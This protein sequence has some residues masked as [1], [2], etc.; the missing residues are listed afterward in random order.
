M[1]S[2]ATEQNAYPAAPGGRRDVTASQ[3]SAIPFDQSSGMSEHT[4]DGVDRRSVMQVFGISGLLGLTGYTAPNGQQMQPPQLQQCQDGED[5]QTADEQNHQMLEQIPAIDIPVID[6]YHECDKVWFIHTSA[7]T[8]KMAQRLTDMINYPTLHVPKLDE[9]ADI[10]ALADIYVFKNGI[11]QT[12]V[13]PWGGGPFGYQIDIL[14]SVPGDNEYTPL[15]HP[16]VVAWKEG[17]DP[18]ILE[19]VDQLMAAK[20]AGRLTIK[21]TNMVVTAPVVSWPGDP[22]GQNLHVRMG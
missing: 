2:T 10:D 4:S 19:S 18:E 9:I 21:P 13:E 1:Q 15:R 11:D 14:D 7:S 22:F 5:E 16:N 8:E 12:D 3:A 6:G 20:R 17:A